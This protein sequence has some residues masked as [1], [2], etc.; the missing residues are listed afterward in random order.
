VIDATVEGIKASEHKDRMAE[1]PDRKETLLKQIQTA[2]EGRG[3]GR[4]A[5]ARGHPLGGV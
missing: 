1:L 4:G 3:T 2:H 5:A